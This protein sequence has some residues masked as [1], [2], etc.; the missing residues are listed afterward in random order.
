MSYL[1]IVTPDGTRRG[2]MV[3]EKRR[4]YPPR[5]GV[6]SYAVTSARTDALAAG[7]DVV[8]RLGYRG[9][10]SVQLKRDSRDGRLYLVEINLR[11]PLILEIAI[12]AGRSFPFYYYC[13]CL[14]M[15]FAEPPLRVGQ[16]WMSLSRD[17]HSMRTY[18]R[19]G[20]ASW[21]HWC[22]DWLRQPAFP[23]FR[24]DDP[25]PAIVASWTWLHAALK[26]RFASSRSALRPVS[27][28]DL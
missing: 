8:E 26:A 15:D 5:F 13:I 6:G 11:L 4:I 22:W 7:R 2:E 24:W 3:A 27:K 1:V 18:A 20:T 10:A 25:A 21:V 16:T 14:G 17:V 12:R 23:V 28:T 19:E 9:F